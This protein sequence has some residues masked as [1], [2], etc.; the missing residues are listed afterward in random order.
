MTEKYDR[1]Q[2]N[3]SIRKSYYLPIRYLYGVPG[4]I[5]TDLCLEV[6]WWQGSRWF[7]LKQNDFQ[8]ILKLVQEGRIVNSNYF[9]GKLEYVLFYRTKNHSWVRCCC[10]RNLECRFKVTRVWIALCWTMKA[11]GL[12]VMCDHVLR[13]GK[14]QVQGESSFSLVFKEVAEN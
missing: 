10:S 4:E 5:K 7:F 12:T 8:L 1:T 6:V 3:K 14:Q 2:I 11:S 13:W 9:Q